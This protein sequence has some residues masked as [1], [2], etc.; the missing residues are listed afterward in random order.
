MKILVNTILNMEKLKLFVQS[1][2]Q[3]HFE[4]NFKNLDPFEKHTKPTTSYNP[5]SLYLFIFL[6]INFYG[7]FGLGVNFLVIPNFLFIQNNKFVYNHQI[8]P[9]KAWTYSD[10]ILAIA[11]FNVLFVYISFLFNT[12]ANKKFY[13]SSENFTK[14]IF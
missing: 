12:T 2:T 4:A 9:F 1:F 11:N 14:G 5:Y 8:F 3:F 13:N 7:I 6:L 10:N